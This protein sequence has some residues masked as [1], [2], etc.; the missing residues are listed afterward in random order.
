MSAS[1]SR[2]WITSGSPVARA[3]TMWRRKPSSCGR[4]RRV[5]VVI[6]EPG[7]ADGD[8]LRML[9]ARDQIV[10]GYVELLIGVMRMG[11][12]RAEDVWNFSAIAST[13]ACFFTRVEMV[14]M[15]PTPAAPARAT[16]VST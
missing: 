1:Q 5:V 16:S 4:A 11:A 12:D 15:R 14:T 6:V 10:G 7:L 9:R 8:D 2:E 13:C 3:A